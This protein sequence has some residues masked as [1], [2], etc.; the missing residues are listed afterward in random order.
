MLR[1][2]SAP[3]AEVQP[4]SFGGDTVEITAGAAVRGRVAQENRSAAAMP[5]SDARWVFAAAVAESLQG[6]MAAA[7][8]PD[9]RRRLLSL[10]T[11]LRL[12]PFDANLV[13][14][15]IQDA[16]RRGCP[17]LSGET[18]ERLAMVPA[19]GL[20]EDQEWLGRAMPWV[21]ACV[22]MAFLLAVVM[23]RWIQ[24]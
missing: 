20:G 7:L 19:A 3:A 15:I 17:P 4:L 13:I 8:P 22:A 9:R 16:A 1:L 21:F 24:G 6:G 12:R 18:E 23:I 2:V 11:R 10:A 14:A 5:A